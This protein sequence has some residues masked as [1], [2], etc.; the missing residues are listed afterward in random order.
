MGLQ[1]GGVMSFTLLDERVIYAND[2]F[3]TLRRQMVEALLNT[4]RHHHSIAE[5]PDIETARLHRT[6]SAQMREDL[7][8]ARRRHVWSPIILLREPGHSQYILQIA[9]S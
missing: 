6:A 8:R 7:R 4:C 9:L 5:Y 2:E 1:N 3:G